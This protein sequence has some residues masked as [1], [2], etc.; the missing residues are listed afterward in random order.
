MQRIDLLAHRLV[1]PA[2]RL[3]ML[4]QRLDHL[5]ARLTAAG[6]AGSHRRSVRLQGLQLRLRPPPLAEQERRLEHLGHRLGRAIAAEQALRTTRLA[7]LNSA[8]VALNPHA[9][10]A[11]GFAIVRDETGAVVRDAGRLSAD[12]NVHLQFEHGAAIAIVSKTFPD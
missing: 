5:A 3:D 12:T 10:L 11:R 7:R 2:Q 8:L 9:T 4:G 1:H 6:R